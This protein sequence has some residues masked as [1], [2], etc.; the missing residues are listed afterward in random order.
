MTKTCIVTGASSGI[1][2]HS[3]L[4][5][6][7]FNHRV[8]LICRDVLKAE[9]TRKIICSLTGNPQ[10]HA[11]ASD[12][13]DFDQIKAVSSEIT[14]QF[15][16]VEILIH[17]AGCVS[18][19]KVM[20]KQKLE[21]QFTVNHL[22][23]FLLTHLLIPILKNNQEARVICVSSRA[24][25]RGTIDFNNL[26]GEKNYSL[27]TAYNQSKLANLMFVYKLARLLSGSNI[28]INAF[29]PGLVNT[30]IGNKNVSITDDILWSMIKLLGASP[31]KASLDA[32][33]LALS[34]DLTTINGKYYHNKQQII[35]SIESYDIDHQ[36]KIW[37]LSLNLCGIKPE[38]YGKVS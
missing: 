17:N 31:Q 30:A 2:F 35:S 20:T 9:Q 25:A 5:L 4:K 26:Q 23:P 21:M 14:S 8:V 34:L 36:E 10:I 12:L 37:E 1:G 24:H 16:K 13:S 38:N 32:I 11:F 22:A 27:S 29:H 19:A 6:A 18:S 15:T 7:K 28:S 33:Y 3:A